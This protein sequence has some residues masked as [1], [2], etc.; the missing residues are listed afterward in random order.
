MIDTKKDIWGRFHQHFTPALMSEDPKKHK[1]N[2]GSI[3]FFALLEYVLVKAAS[4][5]LVK[6]T[7]DVTKLYSVQ[8]EESD[9][10][11][12]LSKKKLEKIKEENE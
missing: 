6:S 8:R 12:G 3:V 7:P 1:K 5:M 2:D 11:L 9:T 4:K 10:L